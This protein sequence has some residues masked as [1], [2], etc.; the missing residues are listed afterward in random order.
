MKP[1]QDE[2]VVTILNL[3]L[4]ILHMPARA[5][6]WNRVNNGVTMMQMNDVIFAYF[7]LVRRGDVLLA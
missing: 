2:S 3:N 5:V 4:Y 1:P 6:C 7:M